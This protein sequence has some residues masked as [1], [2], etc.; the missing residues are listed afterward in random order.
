MQYFFLLY[1]T[2]L[3]LSIWGFSIG[4]TV[5]FPPLVDLNRANLFNLV[6]IAVFETTLLLVPLAITSL[7][8]MV[9]PILFTGSVKLMSTPSGAKIFV[10]EIDTHLLTPNV[11]RLSRGPH[12][13]SLLKEGYIECEVKCESED[14]NIIRVFAGTEQE[15]ECKLKC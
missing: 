6:S 8:E 4:F 1:G 3:A 7:Y 9:K 11:L 14:G 5:Y 12:K 10:D 15:Y 2:M 13:I